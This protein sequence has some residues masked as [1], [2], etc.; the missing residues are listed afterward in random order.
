MEVLVYFPSFF[1]VWEHWLVQFLKV[2]NLHVTYS[3][4]EKHIRKIYKKNYPYLWFTGSW[5]SKLGH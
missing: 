3:N 1:G 4:L 2:N 5:E